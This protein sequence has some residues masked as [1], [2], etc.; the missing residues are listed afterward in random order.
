MRPERYT[1]MMQRIWART[2]SLL[3]IAL[4]LGTWSVGLLARTAT[5]ART[6]VNSSR[7]FGPG[8]CGPVDA[9]YIT[10]ANETGGQPFFM[11]PAEMAGAAHIMT[12]SSRSDAALILWASGTA[13]AAA[14]GFDIPVDASIKR[15]TVSATFDSTGGSVALL[16]PDGRAVQGKLQGEDTL[17]NCGRVISIDAP[18]VGIWRVS[19]APSGRF[20]LVAR[21]RSD[22]TLLSVDFVRAGGRPGHEGLFRIQGQPIGGKPAILRTRFSDSDVQT[23]EFILVS[24]DG[25]ALRSVTL[26][27]IDDEE[28][29]GGIQL[30]LEPFRVAMK[31]LDAAGAPYQRLFSGLF[32]AELVELRRTGGR[33]TIA[34]GED[35]AVTFSV[36]NVG[37]RARY[38]VVAVEARGLVTRVEPDVLEIEEGAEVPVAVWLRAPMNAKEGMGVELTITATSSGPRASTNSA[39]ERLTV[40]RR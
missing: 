34:P 20:W 14:R 24:T 6:Q 22:L 26:A 40:A 29:S 10:I 16:A 36:R 37:P 12:E 1:E 32:H 11:S 8:A 5:M 30:P 15:L 9:S 39:V 23:R 18:Q 13:A 3:L 17:L 38:R 31:G 25:R 33:E 27:P 2:A 21:G 35:M 28:F 19:V 7:P 4:P